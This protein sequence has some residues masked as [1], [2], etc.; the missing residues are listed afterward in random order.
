MISGV[1]SFENFYTGLIKLT[2]NYIETI[3]VNKSTEF[4]VTNPKSRTR[5]EEKLLRRHR[6]CRPK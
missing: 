1:A 4:A 3:A 5:L 6:R 2:A